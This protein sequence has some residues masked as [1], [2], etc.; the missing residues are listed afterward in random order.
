[1]QDTETTS[2]RRLGFVCDKCNSFLCDN[3]P[4]SYLFI[5]VEKPLN[6]CV[7]TFSVMQLWV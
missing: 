4:N 5:Y 7:D 1:M 6:E 3:V 2:E